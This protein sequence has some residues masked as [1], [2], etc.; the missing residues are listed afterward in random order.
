MQA[1]AKEEGVMSGNI[2]AGSPLSFVIAK[3]EGK[4]KNEARAVGFVDFRVVEK[5][6]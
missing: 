4:S 6:E 2:L 3:E 5:P 1:I